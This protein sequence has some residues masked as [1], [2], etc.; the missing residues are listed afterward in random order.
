MDGLDYWRLCE[1]LTIVQAALLIAG[2]DP[3]QDAAYV[4]GW[5]PEN[6]PPGYE[7]A[8]TAISNAL[9]RGTIVGRLLPIYAYD[10]ELEVR[11]AVDESI[12][13]DGSRVEV[14]S[15]RAWL[16]ERGLRAG[17]FFPQP[18]NSPDYLDPRHPRYAPK[19]AAAVQAWLETEN[20]S[21][22]KGKSPK[23]AL[24]KWLREHAAEFSLTDDDGKPNETGI[25]E[26]AKVANWQPTGGAPKTPG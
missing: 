18:S 16:A 17:F 20:E 14:E 12:D 23:Q 1:E 9:R 15:L 8:K 21:A 6:R 13:L 24:L 22:I 7:A 5:N 11:R 3:S 2:S 25:E 4:E 10:R 19:L 26:A